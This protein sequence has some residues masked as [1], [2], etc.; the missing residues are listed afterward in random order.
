MFSRANRA[1]SSEQF[2]KRRERDAFDQGA[3]RIDRQEEAKAEQAKVF[4]RTSRH[5]S[6]RGMPFL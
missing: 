1:L 6:Q 5:D 4:N 3:E 2:A